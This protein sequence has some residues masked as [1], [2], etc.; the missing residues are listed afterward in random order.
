MLREHTLKSSRTPA[1]TSVPVPTLEELRA[2]ELAARR[3]R[4]Q[5]VRDAFRGAYA[6]LFR[7]RDVAPAGKLG[8][9][10]GQ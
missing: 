5:V 9:A 3:M 8:T 1:A 10:H 4:A 7:G 6:W 2:I